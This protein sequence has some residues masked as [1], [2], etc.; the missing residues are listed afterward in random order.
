MIE[1]YEML[2]AARKRAKERGEEWG[3]KERKLIRKRQLVIRKF[4]EHR[5]KDFRL[6]PGYDNL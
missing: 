3:E 6:P 4:G 2:D 1:Y 5:G